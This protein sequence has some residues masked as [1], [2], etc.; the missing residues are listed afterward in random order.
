MVQELVHQHYQH[1]LLAAK[2][3]CHE[4][5]GTW[6]P[7]RTPNVDSY[8]GRKRGSIIREN[9]S[10]ATGEACEHGLDYQDGLTVSG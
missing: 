1:V 9:V 6:Y 5:S 10:S 4:R 3:G 8:L 2:A 7:S